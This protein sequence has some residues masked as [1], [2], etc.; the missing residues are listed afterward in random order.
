MIL[1]IETSG[2]VASVAL[3]DGTAI[4]CEAFQ[5][6][7][8]LAT[9]LLPRIAAL[10]DGVGASIDSVAVFAVGVGPGSFTGLRIGVTTA[11][12]LAHA[13][14]RPLVGVGSLE[15]L[16]HQA[17]AQASVVGLASVCPVLASKRGE[18][19]AARFVVAEGCLVGAAPIVPV[20]VSDLV[21]FADALPKPVLLAGVEWTTV[22]RQLPADGGVI[23][24]G[25][26][27]HFASA[28][29]LVDLARS[30]PAA[31]PLDVVPIYI[32]RSQAEA[33]RGEGP[34]PWGHRGAL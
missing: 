15:I 5:S 1:A 16:A 31:S 19:Y 3:D 20:A 2:A 27:A 22:A 14:A 11:R 21:A 13:S 32:R 33:A 29:V 7:Q 12:S 8:Q 24:A 25:P 18:V 17:L 6:A 26:E 23:I 9:S 34:V 28:A 10:L 4:R 30:R